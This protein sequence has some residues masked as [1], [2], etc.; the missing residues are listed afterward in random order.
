MA[1]P[2]ISGASGTREASRER[3]DEEHRH[4][5]ALLV[6]LE[7][8]REPERIERLLVRLRSQLV[9]HFATEEAPDGLHE[10]VSQNAAHRL[11]NVQQLFDEHREIVHRLDALRAHA[12]AL[13]EGA[14]RRLVEEIAALA[15][16][17][18]AHEAV[19][20]E[21]FGEAFYTDIGGRA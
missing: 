15:A 19:E 7:A 4:L 16:T 3:I 13:R 12:A 9:A 8:A 11:P 6:E 17:L 21:I 20:D 14:F 2:T 1:D 10:I 5:D 18:R